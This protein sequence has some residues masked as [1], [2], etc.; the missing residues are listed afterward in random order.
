MI[1]AN[2]GGIIALMANVQFG[3]EWPVMK[4]PRKTMGADYLAV[5]ACVTDDAIAAERLCGRPHPAITRLVYT[6]PEAV[7]EGSSIVCHITM[8]THN[9]QQDK[10]SA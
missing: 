7:S 10:E 5:L 4:L 6:A 2:T 1:R 9:S 8:I 3:G